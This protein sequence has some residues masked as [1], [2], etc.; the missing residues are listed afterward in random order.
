MVKDDQLVEEYAYNANGL[1]IYER[2]VLRG[3][4]RNLSCSVEDH[5]L[6]AGTATYD[7]HLDGFL[8]QKMEGSDV[9]TYHY[10]SRGEPLGVSLPD[11]AAVEF[12]HGP[13]AWVLRI[14]LSRKIIPPAFRLL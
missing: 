7:Y 13:L 14:P 6:T 8:T 5:L 11:G 4:E 1:R 10:S 12:I 2:N 3:V 9:T